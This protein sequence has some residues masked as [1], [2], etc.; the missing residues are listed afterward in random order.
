VERFVTKIK[1]INL[2]IKRCTYKRNILLICFYFFISKAYC[3]PKANPPNEVTVC[4]TC[5]INSIL[6]A[7][8]LV[9]TSGTITVQSGLYK[10][11]GPIVIKK[12]LTLRG[13][14]GATIDG[15]EKYQLLSILKTNGVVIEGFKI[16]NG[17]ASYIEDL[18]GIK[19]VE[20][21]NCKI[22]NNYFFNN[23]YAVYLEKSENC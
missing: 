14:E 13:E 5:S 2:F 6:A 23:T 12:P 7:V 19:S 16:Q 20:S 4:P 21:Q 17:G 1:K 15:E 11:G 9:A 18:A 8:E 3:L 22:I 10:E